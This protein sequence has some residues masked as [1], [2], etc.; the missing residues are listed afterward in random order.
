[1]LTPGA[2]MRNRILWYWA[3]TMLL[4][5]LGTAQRLRPPLNTAV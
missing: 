4:V 5:G 2:P 1:M 3:G